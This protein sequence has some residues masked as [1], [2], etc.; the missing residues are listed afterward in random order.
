MSNEKDLFDS[1]ERELKYRDG[2]LVRPKETE[3]VERRSSY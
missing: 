2:T 1:I 3:K